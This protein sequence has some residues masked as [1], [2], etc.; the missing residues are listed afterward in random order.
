MTGS[1]QHPDGNSLDHVFAVRAFAGATID[2]PA[3]VRWSAGN[4]GTAAPLVVTIGNV[5]NGRSVGLLDDTISHEYMIGRT[6]AAVDDGWPTISPYQSI[7]PVPF[8]DS[9]SGQ[10]RLRTAEYLS[11]EGSADGNTFVV[12][13]I[14]LGF[15][16]E[17]RGE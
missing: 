9:D 10:L 16:K 17:T 12:D 7:V 11:R 5:S 1:V 14:V 15:M 3:E 4:D 8:T 2:Q 6:A 13:E